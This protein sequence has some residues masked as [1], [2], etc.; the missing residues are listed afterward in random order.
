MGNKTARQFKFKQQRIIVA[1][2][3]YNEEQSISFVI[4][5]I[6]SVMDE[7]NYNYKIFVLNDGSSDSTEHIAKKEGAII[8]SHKTRLGLA[9]T[10]RDEISACL[11]LGAE[12]IVHTDA[13]SQYPAE[14][15]PALI[16]KVR[17]G[18]DLVLGSRFLAGKP[19]LPSMKIIGNKAFAYVISNLIN[20]NI[21]DSTT[22]FRAFTRE[23]AES[24]DLISTF[25]YTQEQVLHAAKKGYKIAEIPVIAR[26]TRQ[27][28]LFKSPFEY[29]VK[30]WITIFRIYRDY[31]PL[32]FFGKVGLLFILIGAIIGLWLVY[33]FIAFGI[34][35]HV[36][37]TILTVLL[38]LTG[39]QI[40]FFGFL[41][42]MQN[43]KK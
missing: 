32:K 13:D 3:A 30:A 43:N 21:T 1:I 27:S 39:I 41:A 11:N 5:E 14:Y 6:K 26:K 2:P 31:N 28:R 42:D 40:I 9:Q 18:Y 24:V 34:V 16:K 7:T 29:A 23:M 15:I 37:A 38:I 35:G 25:T 4:K 17:E 8:V 33:N 12:I 10:F 22:G 19:P 36:P 20:Q